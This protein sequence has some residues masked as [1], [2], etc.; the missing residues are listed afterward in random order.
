MAITYPYAVAALADLLRIRTVT[1]DVRRGDELS[2]SGDGRFWQA[3][4][5]PP[6]WMALVELVPGYNDDVKRIAA[7]IRK[8]HGA[9]EAFYLYDPISPYPQADPTGS[10]VGSSSVTVNSITVARRALTFT[11]L[12][13][14]YRLTV[15]DKFH[16]AYG[17]NPVRRYFGEVSEAAQASSGGTTALFEVFPHVPAGVVIGNAVTLRKPA[18]KMFIVP[19]SFNPGT[20]DRLITSGLAFTALE[21]KP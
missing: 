1:W 18:C 16:I 5:T 19:D 9:Q 11:G 10:I 21:R 2:G 20:A 3:E 6:L 17:S 4:L 14:G 7:L 15:G 12:P 8:L 13:S